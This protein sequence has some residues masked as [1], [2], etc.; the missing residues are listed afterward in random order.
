MPLPIVGQEFL[1]V[2]E[3]PKLT[4]TPAGLAVANFRVK[5]SDRVKDEATGQWKDGKVLWANV[6]IWRDPA[7]HVV[8]SLKSGDLVLITGKLYTREFEHQGQK[9]MSVEIDATSVG[10]SLTFRTTPHGAAQQGQGQQAQPPAQQQYA[11]P[12]G[13]PG[14]GQPQGQPQGYPPQGQP[15]AQPGYGAPQGQPAQ[16]DP[17]APPGG[18]GQQNPPF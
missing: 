4:F 3:D 11:Q 1:I 9:R 13:Q 17:W 15:Q 18:Y 12:Q 14:Y 5:A 8:D 2:G 6:S 10:A 7:Q 16:G